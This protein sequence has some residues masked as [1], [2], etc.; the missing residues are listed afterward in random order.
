MGGVRMNSPSVLGQNAT[1]QRDR[2]EQTFC[3]LS[4]SVFYSPS[5]NCIGSS[6]TEP[7][8]GIFSAAAHNLSVS[9]NHLKNM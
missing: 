7:I 1:G 6:D 5:V 3:F 8:S 2:S 9:V 4:S